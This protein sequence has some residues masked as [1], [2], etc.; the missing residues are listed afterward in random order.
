MLDELLLRVEVIK[1]GVGVAAL[2]G[3]ED[4]YFEQLGQL[5]EHVDGV[6]PDVDGGLQLG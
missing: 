5:S 3:S 6:G 4:D 2:T 1:N